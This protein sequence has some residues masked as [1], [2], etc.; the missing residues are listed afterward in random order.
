MEDRWIK[1]KNGQYPR[2]N[3]LIMV[4]SET[5]IYP[6]LLIAEDQLD[7]WKYNEKYKSEYEKGHY[8]GTKLSFHGLS[9]WALLES[10]Y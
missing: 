1:F 9:H 2:K 3:E 6:H 4:R 5:S 10:P 8:S 7:W